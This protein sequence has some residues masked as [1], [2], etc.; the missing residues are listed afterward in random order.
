MK[1]QALADR[2]PTCIRPRP[3]CM[4]AVLMAACWQDAARSSLSRRHQPIHRRCKQVVADM[5]TFPTIGI[6]ALETD[7]Y[8]IARRVVDT[9]TVD[10]LT[11]ALAAEVSHRGGSPNARRLLETCPAVADLAA[12]SAIC[13]LVE[14]VLGEAAFAV[15][16]LLFDKVPEAN[17]RVGWHQDLMI[18]VARRIGT[19]GFSAWSTKEGVTHVRP[20][21]DVLAGMLTLRLHLDD[22]RAENGPLEVLPST[23]CLGIVDE[24]DVKQVVRSH[25]P[26]VCTV[27]AGDVLVM[28][29]LLFHASQ[30]A[31]TATHRRVVHLEFAAAPLPGALEWHR[32]DLQSLK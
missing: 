31:S 3:A 2:Q 28:R 19:P 23:H 1:M 13:A 4:I 21:A 6:N 18:P 30:P 22:C 15:R 24:A 17:W 8:W 11:Q 27:A 5:D 7:G 25:T 20:P 26:V 16:G 9:A 10:R 29:P 12:S 32:P 14:P